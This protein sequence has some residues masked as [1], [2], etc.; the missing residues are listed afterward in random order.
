MMNDDDDDDD[1]DHDD[2]QWFNVHLKADYKPAL[3]KYQS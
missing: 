1:D 3:P 2:V